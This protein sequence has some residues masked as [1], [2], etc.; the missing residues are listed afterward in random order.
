MSAHEQ[1]QHHIH[2]VQI[3]RCAQDDGVASSV[4]LSPAKDL[5]GMFH[6]AI[7]RKR[8]FLKAAPPLPP[9]ASNCFI[10]ILRV[11]TSPRRMYTHLFYTHRHTRRYPHFPHG[12]PQFQ[13]I[14]SAVLWGFV[15][16]STVRKP[17]HKTIPQT[18]VFNSPNSI[19]IPGNL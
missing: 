10:L 16:L 6:T 11:H 14:K 8:I 2:N 4:I 1:R 19:K 15:N 9:R 5:K 13:G 18:P 12:Y 17:L 3:L 7:G